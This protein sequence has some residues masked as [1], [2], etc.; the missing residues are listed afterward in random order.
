MEGLLGEGEGS[1]EVRKGLGIGVWVRGKGEGVKGTVQ[2]GKVPICVMRAWGG[3]V[4]NGG[5]PCYNMHY[6]SCFHSVA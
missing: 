1:E 3:R 4:G 5:R 6:N 2:R